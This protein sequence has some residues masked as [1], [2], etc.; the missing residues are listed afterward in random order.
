MA[1]SRSDRFWIESDPL[2]GGSSNQIEVPLEVGPFFG[3]TDSPTDDARFEIT[4][5]TGAG[6]F[7][8]PVTYRDSHNKMWR[9]NLP[10]ENMGGHSNYENKILV[11]TR[12]GGSK[13]RLE[14]YD[15]D[16]DTSAIQKL[17]SETTVDTTTSSGS[18]EFGYS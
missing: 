7:M 16:R 4:I 1:I 5:R 9:I 13:Y 12:E 8:R 17:R 18:R 3:G 2:F 15:R 6:E 14:V 10:T 11:F